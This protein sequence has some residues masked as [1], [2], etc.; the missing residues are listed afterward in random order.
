MA[1]SETI[2]ASG[3]TVSIATTTVPSLHEARGSAGAEVAYQ[4]EVLKYHGG[5]VGGLMSRTT[6]MEQILNDYSR[7]GWRVEHVL[8]PKT[9]VISQLIA[10]LV[11]L[12]TCLL[13]MPVPGETL[14]LVKRV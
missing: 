3:S 14:V 9:D 13:Y 7:R 11:L 2:V 8:P 12:L 5:I 10:L 6:R 1:G 4:V